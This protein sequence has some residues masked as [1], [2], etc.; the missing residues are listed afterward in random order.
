MIELAREAMST[1]RAILRRLETIE[2][3]LR[4]KV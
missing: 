3:L 4:E 1:L 2:Q